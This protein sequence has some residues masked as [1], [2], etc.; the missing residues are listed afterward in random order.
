[1][2]APPP[3]PPPNAPPP[4]LPPAPP[5]HMMITAS[6]NKRTAPLAGALRFSPCTLMA[7]RGSLGA[8]QLQRALLPPL[9][10]LL[11]L[12]SFPQFIQTQT[13]TSPRA[14]RSS[15]STHALNDIYAALQPLSACPPPLLLLPVLSGTSACVT[16]ATPSSPP[17]SSS[18]SA[19]CEL[20]GRILVIGDRPHPSLFHS[21]TSAPPPQ[22]PTPSGFHTPCY[23]RCNVT[24][25]SCKTR[26][27]PPLPAPPVYR[28]HIPWCNASSSSSSRVT[29]GPLLV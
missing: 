17:L 8:S 12:F 29:S 1:M 28:L 13:L 15:Q 6:R 5:P 2:G 23:L 4:S 27:R 20:A 14:Q 25:V 19:Q 9:P 22:T 7:S 11:L 16:P 3:P 18:Y 26:P 10:L 24:V 21:S